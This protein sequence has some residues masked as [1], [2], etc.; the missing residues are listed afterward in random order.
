MGT[1][2]AFVFC[3]QRSQLR[4]D[5][6]GHIAAIKAKPV[7]SFNKTS[8]SASV[9]LNIIEKQCLK[10]CSWLRDEAM[11]ILTLEQL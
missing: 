5:S 10:H 4:H 3:L 2:L 1:V 11:K 6:Q 7:E 8:K 9:K